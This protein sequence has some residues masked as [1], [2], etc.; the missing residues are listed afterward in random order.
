MGTLLLNIHWAKLLWY[1]YFSISY[2]SITS[3]KCIEKKEINVSVPHIFEVC[4]LSQKNSQCPTYLLKGTLQP[5]RQTAL[6][7]DSKDLMSRLVCLTLDKA[8]LTF[9]IYFHFYQKMKWDYIFSVFI[10]WISEVKEHYNS[11]MLVFSLGSKLIIERCHWLAR[12]MCPSSLRAWTLESD[13]VD[14]LLMIYL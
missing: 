12:K 7:Q 4:S 5:L 14:L 2:T 10:S 1:I 3:L 9:L 6:E 8:T 13:N 11:K